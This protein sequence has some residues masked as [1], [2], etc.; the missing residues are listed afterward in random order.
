MKITRTNQP[1]I[2]QTIFSPTANIIAIGRKEI[3][4]MRLYFC[5]QNSLDRNFDRR[6]NGFL[7]RAIQIAVGPAAISDRMRCR[8]TV[9]SHAQPVEVHTLSNLHSFFTR[10]M[11]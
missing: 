6:I 9:R 8:T 11:R 10:K 4:F 3:H 5:I 7:K 1:M 2:H